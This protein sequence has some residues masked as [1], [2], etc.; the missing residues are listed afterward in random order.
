[1][2]F[3]HGNAFF[4]SLKSAGTK[5]VAVPVTKK[6]AFPQIKKRSRRFAGTLG[7]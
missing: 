2:R 3:R 6:T 1:M 5:R 7:V 4:L